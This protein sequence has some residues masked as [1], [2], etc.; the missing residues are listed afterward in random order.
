ME[1]KVALVMFSVFFILVFIGV[2]IAFAI[3]VAT[4]LS[5]FLMF[6]AW[7]AISIVAQRMAAGLD[8]FALLAIPFFILAGTLMNRG[9]IAIRLINFAKAMVGWMPGSLCHVNIMANMLFGAISGSATAAAAAIGGTLDP[10][11]KKEG[12]NAPFAAAVNIASC[13]TGLLI[14]PSNV[15]IV[16]ALI[17]GG[18]S[19]AAL[20]LAGYIPG[21]IMGMA[22]MMV[23][24]IIAKRRGYPVS[25][26]ATLAEGLR[27]FWEALPSLL[28]IVIVIG[29]IVFGVF[30][31]TE[32][33]AVAV[34]YTF[35][36]AVFIYR[37]IS[38]AEL[39][40]LI[41]E[42]T[43]MTAVVLLLVG[44]SVGMSWA[45]TNADIPLVVSDFIL[46][47][48]DSPTLIMLLINIILLIVGVFMDMTPAVLI[49]TPIFLPIVNDLGIDNLHFGIIMVYNL[50]IGLCTPPVG[51][52]LFVGCSISGVKIQEV[53][54]P[55][56]PLYAAQIA[57]LM[58]VTYIPWLSKVLPRFFNLI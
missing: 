33:S 28:L 12:Y 45:M 54:R 10:I 48:T 13:V 25:R 42:S 31:A 32:G 1:A 46:G 57:G 40:R 15:L 11:Q 4:I 22:L 8:N 9:G 6:P 2:P 44:I 30:T 17:A 47:I 27:T 43:V 55:L 21:I 24:G 18:I 53:F 38:F 37:T 41:L 36:W 29:G 7:V 49:F 26:R 5:M 51:T 39:P 58:L 19:V 34:V 52:A 20:F 3:G 35:I 50:C 23:T 16:Y 56:L 14:P